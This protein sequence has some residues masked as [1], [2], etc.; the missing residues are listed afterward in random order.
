LKS[1]SF[2]ALRTQKAQALFTIFF[3]DLTIKMAL[4]GKRSASSSSINDAS[5]TMGVFLLK[6]PPS[7]VKMAFAIVELK[8]VCPLNFF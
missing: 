5:I 3:K 7:Q 2:Q 4:K 1:K 8:R 6:K